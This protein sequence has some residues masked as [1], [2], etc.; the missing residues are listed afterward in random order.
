MKHLFLFVSIILLIISLTFA[1][2]NYT[3]FTAHAQSSDFNWQ[4][5]VNGLVDQPLHLTLTDLEA[6]PQTTVPAVIYCVDFPTTVV[7]QGN[8]Q[9]V[10]LWTLLSRAGV[11]PGALKVVF[12]ASDGYQ[13]D[14]TIDQAK[15]DNI[16][17]AYAK[18]GAPLSEVLRIVVPGHWG[19]KWVSQVVG[20]EIVNYDFKGKWESQGYSDDGS[21]AQTNF[22]P[23]P[24][25]L[26]PSIPA[27]TIPSAS[28]SPTETPPVSPRVNS[29]SLST[30]AASLA[31]N[32]TQQIPNAI[33][34][35]AVIAAVTAIALAVVIKKRKAPLQR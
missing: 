21:I 33:G 10:K 11:L 4:L 5:N 24:I 17:V 19:Y 31:K 23:N 30:S 8:W 32:P 34:T 22:P 7:T 3:L 26:S 9:G 12:S 35:V 16:I 15:N 1:S 20:I 27:Q 2:F 18:D 13:S 29:T 6:L 28:P 25:S 14:L